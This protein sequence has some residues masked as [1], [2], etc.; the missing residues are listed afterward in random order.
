[1]KIVQKCGPCGGEITVEG[2]DWP[3][4]VTQVTAWRDHPCSQPDDRGRTGTGF[5]ATSTA[6][7]TW[8]D[9]YRQAIAEE[10]TTT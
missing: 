4:L 7:T 3:D 6:P 1:M 8:R 9:R 5:A 2:D 10:T